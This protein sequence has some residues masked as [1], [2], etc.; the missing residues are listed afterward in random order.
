MN[1]DNFD[2]LDE[3][4]EM[5]HILPSGDSKVLTF[6]LKGHADLPTCT[7]NPPADGVKSHNI[8]STADVDFLVDDFTISGDCSIDKY[9]T[10]ITSDKDVSW[11]EPI[12]KG[13]RVPVQTD[14]SLIGDYTVVVTAT[15]TCNQSVTAQFLL[16]VYKCDILTIDQSKFSSLSYV[17]D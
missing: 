6:A 5:H 17:V 10:S 8:K 14:M 16:T 7:V 11:L 9:E 15:Y 12:S 13:V 1:T 2:S 3:S 4:Y